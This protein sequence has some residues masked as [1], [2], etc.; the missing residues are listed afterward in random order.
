MY[1]PPPKSPKGPEKDYLSIAPPIDSGKY[2]N[3][4]DGMGT[5]HLSHSGDP[6]S[7]RLVRSPRKKNIS[8]QIVKYC[9]FPT[10]AFGP[11]LLV[12]SVADRWGQSLSWRMGL[13]MDEGL[14]RIAYYYI[15]PLVPS[16]IY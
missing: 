6:V 16:F 4:M 1:K 10:H 8:C 3:N 14:V 13:A 2:F 11:Q 7:T 9:Q 5:L 12:V 15:D